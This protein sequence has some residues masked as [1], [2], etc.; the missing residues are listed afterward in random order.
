M[1]MADSISQNIP[2]FTVN[3]FLTQK[4]AFVARVSDP[5]FPGDSNVCILHNFGKD[6][7]FYTSKP[8]PPEVAYK[9]PDEL[10]LC[11]CCCLLSS[12]QSSS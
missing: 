12:L 6:V 7:L 1:V 3:P 4:L 8:L 2:W 5:K 10:Q 11:H 9:T